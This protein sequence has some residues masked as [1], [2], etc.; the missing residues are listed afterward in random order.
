MPIGTCPAHGVL[1]FHDVLG[2]RFNHNPSHD[3]IRRRS[4]PRREGRRC[5]CGKTHC[6]T[7]DSGGSTGRTSVALSCHFVLVVLYCLKLFSSSA[8]VPH[9]VV[10]VGRTSEL[11]LDS[12]LA[13]KDSRLVDRLKSTVAST[14]LAPLILIP[15]VIVRANGSWWLPDWVCGRSSFLRAKSSKFFVRIQNFLLSGPSGIII[16]LTDPS[17]S[18]VLSNILGSKWEFP[19]FFRDANG[20]DPVRFPKLNVTC[21]NISSEVNGLKVTKV[22]Y[23]VLLVPHSLFT[24]LVS[25]KDSRNRGW[26]PLP[27]LFFGSCVRWDVLDQCAKGDNLRFESAASPLVVQPSSLAV[28]GERLHKTVVRSSKGPETFRQ[29]CRRK[30]GTGTP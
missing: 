7:P 21:V 5:T 8:I 1:V 28:I 17:Q 27:G 25:T 6:E 3:R 20:E 24:Q 12:S 18:T 23:Q 10:N 26:T 29:P 4:F 2:Q 14:R 19:F 22:P 11:S 16:F 15:D 13:Y 30:A 9:S